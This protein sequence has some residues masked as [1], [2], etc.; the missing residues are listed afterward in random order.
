VA[1]IYPLKSEQN[2]LYQFER[3]LKSKNMSQNTI[4][5]YL[6]ALKQ[7]NNRYGSISRKNLSDYKLFLIETNKPQTVN[8]RLCGI[9]NYLESIGKKTL[10]LPPVKIQQKPFLE[11]VISEA[12]YEY[13]K[14][15]LRNPKELFWYFVIRF[16]AATG[17]RISELIQ[18]KVE[19]VKKGYVDLYSKGGKLR[20]IYIPKALQEEALAWLT[21]KE[22]DS[23]FI[24]LNRFGNKMTSKGIAGQLKQLARRHGID[25][26]VVYP[27][28]FRH[29]FAKSF[30][31]RC[32]DISFL[33][34]LMGHESIDTTRIYTRKTA[35]EQ[36][37]IVDQVVDW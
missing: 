27:H 28:S 1:N 37:T 10:K 29:R 15:C 12:D 25:P 34:D 30:L 13:F 16:L 35:T 19:H 14:N 32:N 17:A 26:V 24:F 9:N 4:D 23:G 8:L 21:D 3:Y 22:Q 20:R 2:E 33:A 7:Y 6:F 31:E 36:R 18:F 11:N 5:A